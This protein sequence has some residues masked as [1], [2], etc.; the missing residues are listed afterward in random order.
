[1]VQKSGGCTSWGKG[2][3][4]PFSYKGFSFFFKHLRW[5]FGIA[6]IQLRVVSF[7]EGRFIQMNSWFMHLPIAS[8]CGQF[9]L[10]RCFC[11]GGWERETMEHKQ[12]ILEKN[13]VK[14]THIFLGKSVFFGPA[15]GC[16]KDIFCCNWVESV[17]VGGIF[18]S[19]E[20]CFS[21]VFE[22]SWASC[23]ITS[24]RHDHLILP[25]RG[26]GWKVN[27]WGSSYWNL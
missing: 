17:G 8:R 3:G 19:S 23:R 24:W 5:L 16:S 12:G 20:G 14:T 1:M 21:R 11:W 18:S 13:V 22:D 27:L 26:K 2:G 4:N 9:C 10:G 25:P 7:R 6:S 15:F